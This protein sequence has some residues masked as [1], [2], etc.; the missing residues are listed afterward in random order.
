[1]KKGKLINPIQIDNNLWNIID[2]KEFDNDS[3]LIA[4]KKE[5]CLQ[6]L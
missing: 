5:L 1:M 3:L 2:S 4:R 6:E